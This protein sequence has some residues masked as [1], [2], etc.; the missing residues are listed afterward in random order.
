MIKG[1]KCIMT[2]EKELGHYLFLLLPFFSL[3][4][5]SLLS[6]HGAVLIC[7][8]VRVLGPAKLTKVKTN[9]TS[10]LSTASPLLLFSESPTP[11]FVLFFL[12]FSSCIDL[13]LV[14]APFSGYIRLFCKVYNN[15]Q[16]P[17]TIFQRIRIVDYSIRVL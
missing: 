2:T 9:S 4:L 1:G 13:V 16:Q 7:I 5:F 17:R 15:L 6:V 8:L 14:A 11:F 12:F 3:I 10:C